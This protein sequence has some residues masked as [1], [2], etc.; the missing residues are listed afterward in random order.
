MTVEIVVKKLHMPWPGVRLAAGLR[1]KIEPDE[2]AE[3]I[4]RRGFAEQISTDILAQEKAAAKK[5]AEHP[6]QKGS[7]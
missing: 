2:V 7:K 5:A 3:A 1:M 6:K 4:V